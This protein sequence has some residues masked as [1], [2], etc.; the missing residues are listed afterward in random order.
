MNIPALPL[1]THLKT[2]SKT[3]LKTLLKNTQYLKT[4][5]VSLSGL[6]YFQ[7]VHKG[8]QIHDLGYAKRQLNYWLYTNLPSFLKVL[9]VVSTLKQR[10]PKTAPPSNCAFLA[11]FL[12]SSPHNH[13]ETKNENN[14]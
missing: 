1:K 9:K 12:I 11:W 2:H 5:N 6:R 4:H 8:Y 10:H 7:S 3:H 13:L 14:Y